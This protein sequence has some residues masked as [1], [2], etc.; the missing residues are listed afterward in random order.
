[1]D[2]QPIRHEFK[3]VIEGIELQPEIVDRINRAVQNIVLQEIANFDRHG[4][5]AVQ[6]PLAKIGNGS[7]NGMTVRATTLERAE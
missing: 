4:D 3:V 2:K 1:M 5:L 7:T 6:L